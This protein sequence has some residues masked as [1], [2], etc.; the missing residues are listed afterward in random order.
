MKEFK[1]IIYLKHNV[2]STEKL[3]VWKPR[4]RSSRRQEHLGLY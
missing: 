2:Y 3:R 4:R 1:I